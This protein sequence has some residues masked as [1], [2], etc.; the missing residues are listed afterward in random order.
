MG[1]E[2]TVG[3][4]GVGVDVGMGVGVFV[5]ASVFVGSGV[6]VAVGVIGPNAWPDLQ[7]VKLI[8]TTKQISKMVLIFTF[9]PMRE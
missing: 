5:G 2:V 4:I 7:A 8:P 3:G 1:V 6:I 9:P